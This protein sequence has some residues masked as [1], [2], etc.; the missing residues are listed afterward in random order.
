MFATAEPVN[1]G[2]GQVEGR[3]L[4]MRR[5][6]RGAWR[7]WGSGSHGLRRAEPMMRVVLVVRGECSKRS[8]T[9][10]VNSST[11]CVEGE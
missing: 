10:A 2:A 1:E 6:G 4:R 7:G 8:P 11:N 3:D 5:G 9:S